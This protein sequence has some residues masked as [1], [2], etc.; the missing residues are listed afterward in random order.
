MAPRQYWLLK[1]EPSEFS[2]D[3]LRARPD[4]TEP[5]DGVRNY[6]ARNFLRD[7]IKAGDEALFYHSGKEPAVVGIVTVVRPGYSDHTA[8]D[9]KSKHFDPRST[10]EAPVWFMVDV[11]LNEVFE[12]PLTLT[13]L[14]KMPELESMM[15]LRKGV[16]LSV[17][18]VSPEE[19][20]AIVSRARLPGLS[21]QDDSS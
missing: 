15:L 13:E 20:Q 12:T 18:P 1:S 21:I 4:Q 14:R 7:R 10:P 19:F 9:P 11:R 5:W 3:D 16:R 2:I 8:W 17:Q 6:Q